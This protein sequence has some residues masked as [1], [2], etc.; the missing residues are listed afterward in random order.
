MRVGR[1]GALLG[2]AIVMAMWTGSL[3]ANAASGGQSITYAASAPATARQLAS[4]MRT[5]TLRFHQLGFHS[6]HL[7]VA[8][9]RIVVTDAGHA[10]PSSAINEVAQVGRVLFRPVLCFAP[11][12]QA[13]VGVTPVSGAGVLP[14][15][16]AAYAFGIATLT[17]KPN[18]SV[19]GYSGTTLGPA[20]RVQLTGPRR[21]RSRSA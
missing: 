13:V 15:C 9:Q 6:V 19:Q 4:D 14:P 17:V 8:H 7:A 10:V 2:V 20:G 5:L 16:G 3:P 12:Y 18:S 1:L 11:A 21:G